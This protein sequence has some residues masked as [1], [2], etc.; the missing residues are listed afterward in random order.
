ME[1]KKSRRPNREGDRERQ[2]AE[3]ALEQIEWVISYL[4]RIR[5]PAIARALDRNRQ[6]ILQRARL[7][8]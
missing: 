7:R 1:S 3:A 4:R 8:D 5:K 2:A 6:A